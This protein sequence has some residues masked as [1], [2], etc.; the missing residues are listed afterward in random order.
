MKKRRHYAHHDPEI[1]QFIESIVDYSPKEIEINNDALHIFVSEIKNQCGGEYNPAT[2]YETVITIKHL[3][4]NGK[5]I[6]ILDDEEFCGLRQLL[7]A[8]MKALS[9]QGHGMSKKQADMITEEQEN[10]MWEKGSLVMTY[11]QQLLDTL[12]YQFV[13]HFGL[14]AGQE[15]RNLRVVRKA[16]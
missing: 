4:Q 11:P 3:R 12:L 14:R 13:L 10:I 16:R 7:D 15:H 2:I 5:F 6:S 1:R 8:K 9:K